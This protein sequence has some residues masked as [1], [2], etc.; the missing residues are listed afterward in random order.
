V[1]FHKPFFKYL[2]SSIFE[3]LL[4]RVILLELLTREFKLFVSILIQAFIFSL[5]HFMIGIEVIALVGYFIG[6]LNYGICYLMYRNIYSLELK[7][8]IPIISYPVG[9]HFAWNFCQ[10][11]ILGLPFDRVI[12]KNSLLIIDIPNDS[13]HLGSFAGFEG[14][15]IQ[16]ISRIILLFYL[17]YEFRK[18]NGKVLN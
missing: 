2:I 14:G 10:F 17:I 3:E 1:D 12:N 6:G 11:S 7:N 4:F 5:A 15:Q 8:L 18:V 13:F 16:I 9:L